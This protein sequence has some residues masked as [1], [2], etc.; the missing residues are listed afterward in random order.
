MGNFMHSTSSR[1]GSYYS[2]V[3]GESVEHL[4]TSIKGYDDKQLIQFF[5]GH[6]RKR[7]GSQEKL[8]KEVRARMDVGEN[9]SAG[10]NVGEAIRFTLTDTD[11]DF[12]IQS[13][14]H[15]LEVRKAIY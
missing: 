12:Y 4:L 11:I 9:M 3:R 14:A 8:W 7:L 1:S 10:V 13:H 15:I 5:N 2:N 6:R